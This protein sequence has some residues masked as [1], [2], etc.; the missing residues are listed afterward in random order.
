MQIIIKRRVDGPSTPELGQPTSVTFSSVTVPLNR[1]STGPAP[2]S[3]YT[4]QRSLN[5]TTWTTAA[6]GALIFGNPPVAFVDGGRLALTTYF[7]RAL[8]EDTGGRVSDYCATVSVT[9]REGAGT[10]ELPAFNTQTPT[11]RVSA[12]GTLGGLSAFTTLQ[13]AFNVA[14][15][16]D[17]IAIGPGT[18]AQRAV[19]TRSGTAASPIYVRPWDYNSRPTFD[20]QY[21]SSVVPGWNAPFDAG[22]TQLLSVMANHV[23]VDGLNFIRSPQGGILVGDAANNGNFTFAI[24]TFYS[25]NKIIRCSVI[26]SETAFRTI[27]V[28]GLQVLGCTFLDCQRSFYRADGF[29]EDN[30]TWGSAMSLMGKNI[31]LAENT[32]GQ[33]SGEGI[34]LG[35]HIKFGDDNAF[36]QCENVT[37]RNNRI[38]DCWSAPLYISNV[39]GGVIE[40]NVIYMTNDTRYWQYAA[41]GYPRFAIDI[42]SE[43]GDPS[44]GGWPPPNGFIGARDLIIRNNI[45]TG[46]LTPLL[47]NDWPLQATTRVKVLNNTIYRSVGGTFA[48]GA[49]VIQNAES[50]LTDI[51]FKNNLVYDAIPAQMCRQWLTPGGTWSRGANLFSTAPPSALSGAGDVITASP[52]ILNPAYTPGGTYPAVVEFDTNNIRL[53]SGSPALSAGEALADVT[54][55]FFGNPRPTGGAAY[56]IGAHQST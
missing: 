4:I 32:V 24:S 21:S 52:G 33:S 29:P 14:N 55:D 56:D 6:T 41:N 38:F 22:R 9:T 18:Y 48:A 23:T 47:F 34:H 46:A 40:R 54:N 8:A 51:T 19:M 45:I 37:L 27:N 26:G 43:S 10:S 17:V 30:P 44:V 20:G 7:Y 1:P 42:S 16:G 39:D 35:I 11:I 12:S 49:S 2:I 3:S 25:G 31:L 53:Q 13:A 15:P 36:T 28:D 50:S 5:G